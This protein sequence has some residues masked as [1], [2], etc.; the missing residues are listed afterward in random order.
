M[1]SQQ[2]LLIQQL[3]QL[4]LKNLKKS[5][6][7]KAKDKDKNVRGKVIEYDY[8]KKDKTIKMN[9]K[10]QDGDDSIVVSLGEDFPLNLKDTFVE[11]RD[12]EHSHIVIYNYEKVQLENILRE[13][14]VGHEENYESLKDKTDDSKN[15]VELLLKI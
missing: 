1:T 5:N 13:N 3:I 14:G 15:K 12:F 11:F 8:D 6:D 9:Y 4:Q 10:E 2:D 7:L